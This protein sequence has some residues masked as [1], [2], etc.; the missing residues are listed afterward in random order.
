MQMTEMGEPVALAAY[1][2]KLA[3]LVL[4]TLCVPALLHYYH[5]SG[6][7]GRY[8]LRT[9]LAPLVF[10]FIAFTSLWLIMDL[11]DNLKDFQEAETAL[12]QV[13][14]FYL[15]VLPFIYVSGMPPALTLSIASTV[16]S[17]RRAA[18]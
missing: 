16:P 1:W 9:F 11:L 12:G 13:F 4:A 6:T 5:R 18:R 8:T 3:L 15:G 10:C 7:L 17:A 2:L 14:L